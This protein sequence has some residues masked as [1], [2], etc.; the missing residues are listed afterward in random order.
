MQMEY[1]V[2]ESFFDRTTLITM[3]DAL[4]EGQLFL[5]ITPDPE[6]DRMCRENLRGFGKL[7]VGFMEDVARARPHY[8]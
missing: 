5:S 8:R 7:I 6:A 4:R 1:L 2:S 3:E